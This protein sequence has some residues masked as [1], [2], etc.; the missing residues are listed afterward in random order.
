MDLF[1]QLEAEKKR[2]EMLEKAMKAKGKK[3]CERPIKEL[4]LH[5]LETL[6]G[7]LEELRENVRVRVSEL[8]AS[9][10]LLLLGKRPVQEDDA[11]DS[12]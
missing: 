5:E 7:S 4:S 11:P 8:E 10:S 3:T 9:S 2:G 1:K 6:K 12:I